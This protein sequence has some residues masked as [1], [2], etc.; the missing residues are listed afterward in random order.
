MRSKLY[1]KVLGR[2]SKSQDP[3]IVIAKSGRE[4]SISP[5]LAGGAEQLIHEEQ[6]LEWIQGGAEAPAFLCVSPALCYR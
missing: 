4:L 2:P 5:L 3:V 1:G 6:H